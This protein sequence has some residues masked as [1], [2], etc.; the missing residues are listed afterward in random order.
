[1]ERSFFIASAFSE[2]REDFSSDLHARTQSLSVLTFNC[3]ITSDAT[4][5]ETGRSFGTAAA[6]FSPKWTNSKR[7]SF[8]LSQS[9]EPKPL[10][11][12]SDCASS[13][14]SLPPQFKK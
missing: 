7:S 14:L 5:P 6:L 4:S 11:H 13:Q 10:K 1:L 12:L 9:M 8:H 3:K 2:R